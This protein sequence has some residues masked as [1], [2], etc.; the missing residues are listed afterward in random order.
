MQ[1]GEERQM[2]RVLE[3]EMPAKRAKLFQA[4]WLTKMSRSMVD[5]NSAGGDDSLV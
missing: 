2:E 3:M 4:L 1:S 5:G